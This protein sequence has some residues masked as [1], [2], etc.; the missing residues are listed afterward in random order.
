MAKSQF[1]S[2]LIVLLGLRLGSFVG[3]VL[4]ELTIYGQENNSIVFSSKEPNVTNYE[5]FLNNAQ[6]YCFTGW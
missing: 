6:S 2:L 4:Q 1:A 3:A 5:V